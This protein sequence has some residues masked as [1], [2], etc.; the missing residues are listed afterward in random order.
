MTMNA[1]IKQHS[2]VGL[3]RAVRAAV[4][5]GLLFGF[6]TSI[7]ALGSVPSASAADLAARSTH[8]E[9]TER[10]QVLVPAD[11]DKAVADPHDL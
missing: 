10:S 4:A 8:D 2:V 6:A 9:I 7:V 11:D 1:F 5:V 3:G